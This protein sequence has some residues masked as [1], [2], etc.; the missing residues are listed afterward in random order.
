MV[1]SRGESLTHHTNQMNYISSTGTS[2]VVINGTGNVVISN[3]NNSV[4][5]NGNGTQIV[6]QNNNSQSTFIGSSSDDI[7][8]NSLGSDYIDGG[9]GLDI[10]DFSSNNNTI[11]L[12]K[13]SWQNTGDGNDTLLNIE[14]IRAGGGDDLIYGSSSNE[15][16]FGQEGND[17][18]DGGKGD[19]LISGGFSTKP[20]YGNDYL[21][22]G[23]GNDTIYGHGGDD[24]IIG[25]KGVDELIGGKGSD[26]FVISAKNGKGRK[27]MDKITDFEVG[28]DAIIIEGSPKGMYLESSGRDNYLMKGNDILAVIDGQAGQ[29]S[30]S[31]QNQN[32]YIL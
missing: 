14:G 27:S 3:Q 11:N 19:D 21:R 28:S 2:N 17:S 13:R 20:E 30:F 8:G 23:K 24:V 15:W 9:G 12:N 5:Q 7:F 29:L 32:L 1:C 6:N 22:G 31:Q 26:L 10:V 4:H 16:L 25:G 18:I